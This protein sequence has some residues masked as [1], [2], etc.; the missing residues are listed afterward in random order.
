MNNLKDAKD[1]INSDEGVIDY[2]IDVWNTLCKS[3]RAEATHLIEENI[4]LMHTHYHEEEAHSRFRFK[5]GILTIEYLELPS[6]LQNRGFTTT[7]L[8]NIEEEDNGIIE[9]RFLSVK[10]PFMAE[11]LERK[12]YVSYVMSDL[13]R[14]CF[15]M[16]KNSSLG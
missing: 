6:G 13:P 1:Y 15:K 7:F 2:I 3:Y 10:A 5:N 8:N 11:L 14:K 12:G 4:I 16:R 9:I